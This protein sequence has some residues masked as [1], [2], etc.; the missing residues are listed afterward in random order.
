MGGDD[1][2]AGICGERA[3]RTGVVELS[4]AEIAV[5]GRVGDPAGSGTIRRD[6]E[7]CKIFIE[8]DVVSGKVQPRRASVATRLVNADPKPENGRRKHG[9]CPFGFEYRD[10]YFHGLLSPVAAITN[11]ELKYFT[12]VADAQNYSGVLLKQ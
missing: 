7:F 10:C 12:W 1:K 4:V 8:C 11:G 6:R 5:P 2:A 9:A 3:V